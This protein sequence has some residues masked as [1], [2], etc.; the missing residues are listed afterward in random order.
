MPKKNTFEVSLKKLLRLVKIFYPWNQN[1]YV[2]FEPS[3]CKLK[4]KSMR[5]VKKQKGVKIEL[6]FSMF[7]EVCLI[8][9]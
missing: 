5:D 4:N 7:T 9:K 2:K 6:Y 8:F 3:P 1:R